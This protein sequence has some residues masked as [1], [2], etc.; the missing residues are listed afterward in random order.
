MT[1]QEIA[2]DL[3]AIYP[4][5][6]DP[7]IEKDMEKYSNQA[8]KLAKKYQGKVV[9]FIP[10]KLLSFLQ[11]IEE[12][13]VNYNQMMLY[14]RLS[15][16]ANM[17]LPETQALYSK[18]NKLQTKIGQKLA[19]FRLELGKLLE[20]KPELI[21]DPILVDYKHFLERILRAVPHQLSEVEEQLILEKD[22]NGVDAWQQLQSKWLN[23]RRFEVEVEGEKK[24]LS[25][26]EANGLLPHPDR[27]TRESANKAIYGKLG[28]DGEIF[29][30]ALRNIANDWMNMVERRKHQSPMEAS[31]IANDVNQEIID[32]LLQTIDENSKVYRR[33]LKLKAKMMGLPKLM[34]HDIVAP[35][36]DAPETDYPFEKARELVTEA[37]E[38]FDKDYAFAVR[39]MFERNHIDASP[40]YG[41]RN[42]A[43]CASWFKGQ[44]AF[45]LQSYN[46]ALDNIYTLAHEL[47]HATHDYYFER[48]QTLFNSRIPMVIAEVASIFGELLLTDLLLDKA[49]TKA[50]K[51]SIISTVLDGAGMA[52]FQVSARAW[53]EQSLYNAIEEGKHLDYETICK[54]WTSARDKIYQDAVDWYDEMDAEWTMKVHYYMA[55]FRFYNYPYVFAQLFVYA[56]YEKYLEEGKSF[57]PKFKKVLSSGNSIS[58]KEIGEI[59]DLDISAPDFW[60]L[61]IK[62][63][64]SFVDELEQLVD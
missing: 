2:W 56:L 6:T 29:S 47:G 64:E 61:G 54:F 37:Y 50:E 19:F 36:P 44:S 42:G 55:N 17:T 58:P 51:R 13:Y 45:I 49:K 22:E 15:F 31:L 24:V 57:V 11:E 53:F 10:Q 18:A 32:S 3:S 21:K 20:K 63:F 28:E 16:A 39:D 46:N 14:C 60:Q 4:K 62:R 33:Y 48:A 12:F 43:F 30:A 5:P 35:L 38:R 9:D 25:Y 52:A 40:R 34:C 59:L 27:T 8:D 1:K 23:T 7:A 26:G 41:K